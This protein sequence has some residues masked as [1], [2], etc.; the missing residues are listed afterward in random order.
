MNFKALLACDLMTITGF[1]GLI[2]IIYYKLENLTC[3]VDNLIM[4]YL[5]FGIIIYFVGRLLQNQLMY[6]IYH[7]LLIFIFIGIP[8][9]T[10][11]K[12]ILFW[13]LTFIFLTLATRKIFDGCIISLVERENPITQNKLTEW[14]NSDIIFSI[15]GLF[16]IFNLYK[17]S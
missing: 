17:I 4:L 12:D 2:N 10:Q 9:I 3:Y 14:F 13:H 16:T 6:E 8:F 7:Y 5:Y 11:N 1:T 15:L